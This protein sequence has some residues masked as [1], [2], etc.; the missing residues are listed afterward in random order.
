MIDRVIGLKTTCIP[1]LWN[2]TKATPVKRQE[3]IDRLAAGAM[4]SMIRS[5][6]AGSSTGRLEIRCQLDFWKRL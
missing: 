3:H 4:E 2:R 5:S 6:H 1:Q